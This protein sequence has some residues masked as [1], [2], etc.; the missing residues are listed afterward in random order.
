MNRNEEKIKQFKNRTILLFFQLIS[1]FWKWAMSVGRKCLKW[2]LIQRNK[3]KYLHLH[4]KFCKINFQEP[5]LVRD[6]GLIRVDHTC[7]LHA[8]LAARQS[9]NQAK[10]TVTEMSFLRSPSKPSATNEQTIYSYFPD[11]ISESDIS[12]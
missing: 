8:C 6:Y 7:P 12:F 5:V 1:T 4:S 11:N 3:F 2:Q 10:C 9:M